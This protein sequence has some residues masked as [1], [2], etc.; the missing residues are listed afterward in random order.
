MPALILLNGPPASGKSTLAQ[1]L[2]DRNPLALNLDVDVIRSLLGAWIEAPDESG[3]IARR[4]ALAMA[5]QHLDAGYDVVVPQFLAKVAFIHELESAAAAV[6]AGFAEIVLDVDRHD[7]IE[8]FGARS[9][10]PQTQTHADAAALVGRSTEPDPL[11]A[12]Y[13]DLQRLVANRPKT[14]RV[15]VVADDVETTLATLLDLLKRT[16]IDW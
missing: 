10:D 11:G 7:V 3:L 13:N 15:P 1:R 6:R 14:I 9:V 4:L 12:A 2:V 16:G 8:A 5:T